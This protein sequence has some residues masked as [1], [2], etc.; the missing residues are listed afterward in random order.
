M[1]SILTYTK[2]RD[3]LNY[4]RRCN[5]YKPIDVEG[6]YKTTL[7]AIKYY[8][9]DRRYAHSLATGHDLEARW[10]RSLEAG[11][12]DYSVYSHEHFVGEVWSCWIV[13]SRKYILALRNRAALEGRSILDDLGPVSSVVDLGCGI[14]YTTAGLKE[15]F[16]QA[17]VYGTQLEDSFQFKIASELGAK[18]GFEVKTDVGKVG[19]AD[20]VF[21][22]EYFE[23]FEDPVAHVLEV[24]RKASPRAFI[25][26]NS[27]RARAIGHFDMYRVG[28][29]KVKNTSMG[30]VF[31]KALRDE[32]YRLVKTRL[33]NN[34]PSYW[35]R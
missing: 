26:A 35:V 29:A 24:I 10:Y 27:F 19:K 9:G 14:G 34:R 2:N 3:L 7:G 25:L 13:Y 16:P 33:W 31:G 28:N 15:L 12:P 1:N 17:K 30:R 8:R 22:S 32:G 20:L 23:H 4:L 11:R 21:A 5:E 18:R 6:F